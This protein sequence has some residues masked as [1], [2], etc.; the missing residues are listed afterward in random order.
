MRF[1][2]LHDSELTNQL[3]ERHPNAFL[4]LLL[5]ARRARWKKEPC[6]ILGLSY[7]QALIGDWR[8]AGLPSEK[9]Y[10]CA[11]DAL[12]RG[13]LATFRGAKTGANRGTVAT[14][15]STEVCSISDPTR[16]DQ[17]G[18]QRADEGADEGRTKGGRRATKH[19][20]H[21]EHTDHQP[22]LTPPI[23]PKGADAPPPAMPHGWRNWSAKRQKATRVGRNTELMKRMGRWFGRRPET[24]WT[25]HEAGLLENLNPPEDE[26]DMLEARYLAVVDKEHDYRRRDLATLLANWTQEIDRTLTETH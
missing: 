23:P 15:V 10:R 5:I 11:K 19:T 18:D 12:V 17:R 3:Q 6:P 14:L 1:I 21:T 13:G 4:L 16:G 9:A 8:K 2:A 24:L 20:E 25:V 7:G 22:L 26:L